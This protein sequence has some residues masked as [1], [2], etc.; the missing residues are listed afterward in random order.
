MYLTA[1][2]DDER[3]LLNICPDRRGVRNLEP[4]VVGRE[5]GDVRKDAINILGL[6][7]LYL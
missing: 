2:E 6:S 5:S 4:V 1:E 3:V 7:V